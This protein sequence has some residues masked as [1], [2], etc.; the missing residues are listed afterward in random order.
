MDEKFTTDARKLTA[1]GQKIETHYVENL[2]KMGELLRSVCG[3]LVIVPSNPEGTYFQMVEGILN[4]LKKEEW[5][6]SPDA[7]TV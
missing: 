2:Y 6:Q 5:G 7:F 4:F 1:A 3:F